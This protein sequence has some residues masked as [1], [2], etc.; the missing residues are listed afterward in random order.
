[1]AQS[2]S[3]HRLMALSQSKLS[4]AELLF[5]NGRW[6]N[7]YYLAGYAVEL[8]LKACAAIQFTA[9]SIP[10]KKL[11]LDLHTHDFAKLISSAGLQPELKKKLGEDDLFAAYWA[12]AAEWTPDSR[13]DDTDKS[14]AQYLISAV[15]EQAHGVLPWIRTFW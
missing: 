1:V 3:K 11:I 13:Y 8:A 14:S 12:V 5:A 9:D 6:A 7:A 2:L 15:G 10:A 4:D